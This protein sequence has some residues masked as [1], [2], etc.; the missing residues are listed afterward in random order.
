M[1]LVLERALDQAVRPLITM[2]SVVDVQSGYSANTVSYVDVQPR[3]SSSTSSDGSG[4]A[5]IADSIANVQFHERDLQAMNMIKERQWQEQ[6]Q[7]EKRWASTLGAFE[8]TPGAAAALQRVTDKLAGKAAA[9][10]KTKVERP[11][12]QPTGNV[13]DWLHF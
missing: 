9:A 3:T 6:Q 2:D 5:T 12:R 4:A 7:L 1:L 13:Q 10:P 8:Q 11:S